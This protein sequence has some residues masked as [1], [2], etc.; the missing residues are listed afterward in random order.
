MSGIARLEG[1]VF[2]F[3]YWALEK[4]LQLNE[5]TT[6]GNRLRWKSLPADKNESRNLLVVSI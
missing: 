2:A 3:S 4:L 5:E 1:Y 6:K